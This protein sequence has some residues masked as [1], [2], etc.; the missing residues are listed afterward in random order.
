[1][2]VGQTVTFLPRASQVV[3]GE[4]N[5]F[6]PPLNLTWTKYRKR[7]CTMIVDEMKWCVVCGCRK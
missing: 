2:F 7:G 3:G 5:L 6:W 4:G 1:M